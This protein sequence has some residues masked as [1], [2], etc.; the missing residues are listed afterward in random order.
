M[1]NFL[2]FFKKL[3]NSLFFILG[4]LC[5][6][7]S[8]KFYVYDNSGRCVACPFQ[9]EYY[10]NIIIG[11]LSTTYAVLLLCILYQLFLLMKNKYHKIHKEVPSS[12]GENLIADS[13][14]NKEKHETISHKFVKILHRLHLYLPVHF[15]I[16]HEIMHE[17]VVVVTGQLQYS[18]KILFTGFQVRTYF[19]INANH[20]DYIY[21]YLSFIH[22]ILCIGR[23]LLL[24]I[25]VPMTDIQL[26]NGNLYE[27]LCKCST[28]YYSLLPTTNYTIYHIIY[29]TYS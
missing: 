12:Q 29:H 28:I 2:L 26:H 1:F 5:A 14:I 17:I 23:L 21:I 22:S 15:H 24:F 11:I 8:T 27:G 13:N 7:C 20:N 3:S 10:R 9:P 25:V 4:P 19:I 18:I 6:L 16:R